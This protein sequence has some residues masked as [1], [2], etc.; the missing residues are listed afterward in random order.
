MNFFGCVAHVHVDK[1]NTNKLESKST[2]ISMGC[3]TTSRN[4]HCYNPLLKKVV[5]SRD[6]QFEENIDAYTNQ[7]QLMIPMKQQANNNEDLTL[8]PLGHDI[9]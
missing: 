4:Y 6:V 2:C 1:E 9:C 3:E 5:V 8:F 7:L